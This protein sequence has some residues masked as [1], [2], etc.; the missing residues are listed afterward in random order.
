MSSSLEDIVAR[1]VATK[2]ISDI[3][4]EKLAARLAPQILKTVEARLLSEIKH[5][6]M[7]DLIYDCLPYKELEQALRIHI[8]KGLKK[9]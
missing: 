3:D 1:K 5:M 6:D 8:V 7:S 4:V 9:K 2:V